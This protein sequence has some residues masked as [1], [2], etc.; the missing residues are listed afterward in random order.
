MIRLFLLNL[1]LLPT[2]SQAQDIVFAP[3]ATIACLD[4]A[5][6][7]SER[8]ACIGASADQCMETTDGGETTVGMGGCFWAEYTYWDAR[9]NASYQATL[10]SAKADDA[11]LKAIGATVASVGDALRTMQRAWLPFRD[12]ACDYERAQWGGGTGGGPATA[13]CLMRMTAEQ[14]LTLEGELY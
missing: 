1:M 6:S 10:T 4:E 9:L 7:V 2:V 13:A 11:E 12:A 14:T 5:I 8:L 3:D